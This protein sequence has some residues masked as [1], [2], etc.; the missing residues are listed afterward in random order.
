MHEAVQSAG[1]SE[2]AGQQQHRGRQLRRSGTDDGCDGPGRVALVEL[3]VANLEQ[4]GVRELC[5]QDVRSTAARRGSAMRGVV[6]TVLWGEPLD[7]H[8]RVDG[9]HRP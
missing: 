4:Q 1:E 9:H 6:V 8:G 7:R 3:A 2:S 5:G